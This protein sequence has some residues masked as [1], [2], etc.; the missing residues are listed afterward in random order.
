MSLFT[1][2]DNCAKSKKYF[3]TSNLKQAKSLLDEPTP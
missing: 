3:D 1:T 2:L